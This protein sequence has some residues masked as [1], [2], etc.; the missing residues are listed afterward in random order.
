M[1]LSKIIEALKDKEIGADII[2]AVK[3]LDKSDDVARLTKEL[4]SEKGKAASILEDKRKFKERA[5]ESE[6]KLK[7]IEDA[8]LPEAERVQKQ[9]EELRAEREAAKAELVAE[10]ERVAA[11]E[12]DNEILKLAGTIKWVKDTPSETSNLIVKNRLADVDLTDKAK[13][14]EI[15]NGIKET[16]KAFISADAPGGTGGKSGDGVP[17]QETANPSIIDNQKEIWGGK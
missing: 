8:K 2:S 4:E 15:L 16:H 14:E 17:K 3:E 10:R 7:E 11:K 5:E 13:V 12:R 9:L 1:E 6:K